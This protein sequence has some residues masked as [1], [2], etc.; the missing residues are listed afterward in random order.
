VIKLAFKGLLARKLRTVLTGFA[1]V[2]GVAFVAG[3]FI[4]TDTID[5]SFKDLFERTSKGV[6]VSVQSKL[7]VEAD[8]A[9]PPTMPASTL[10][11]VQSVDGV[12]EAA[13]SVSG[14]VNLLDRDGKPILSNGPPTI[15]VTTGPERFDPLTYVE[16]GK[17]TTDDQIA[18]DKG[19]A[20]EFDF[21]VG[22]KVTVAGRAPAKA[23]DVAGIVTLGDSENLAGSRLVL[24][25]LPEGQRVT[26][27]DG[28]DD[29]SVAADG[30]TSPE[31]LK[32][33]IAKELGPE[34]AVRTGKEQAE[35]QA[36]DLS[37]ALGFIRTALLV[38]AA[39]ALL[40]GSF[41]IFNTFSVTVA[42]RTKEFALLRTIG[43]SRGQVLRSVLVETFVIGLIA[44]LVGIAL[45]LALA[46]GLAALLTSFGIDLGTSGTVLEPRTII[47]GLVVGIVATV[48]SGFVPARRATR[49][50]PVAAMRDSVTPATGK[51]RRRRIVVAFVVEALGIVLLLWGLLGDP[52][53]A[54]TTALVLGLGTLLMIFGFALLAPTLVRPL[55]GVIGRPL[56]RFQGLTGMLARENTR[57]QPQ[58]TAV[59]ASALM[60]GV[61][62]VV[63]VAIF[64]AGLRAT[65]DQGIDEQVK[66]VSIITHQDGFSPLPSEIAGEVEK[67]DGVTAVSRLRFATG[68]VAGE[69]G[70]TTVTGIDPETAR[71]VIKLK[72]AEGSDEVLSSIGTTGVIVPKEFATKH[73]LKVGSP[74]VLEAPRGNEV[75]Y[76]V[77]GI[78]EP[79]AGVIGGVLASNASLEA[80]WD[81]K[82]VAFFLVAGDDPESVTKGEEAALAGF[83]AAK[84]QTIE[85]FKDEQNKQVDALVGLVYALLSLSVIVALLGIVNTLALSVHERTRELGLLRAVGMSRRQVRRMV[86]AESVI[87][88]AIGAVLGIVLGVALAAIVSRPLAQDG[89][90]FE[91]PFGTLIAVVILASIAGVVAAIPP[92]RRA[93]KVDVLRAVTTE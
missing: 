35:K 20:D 79:G 53:D 85:G 52:G 10:E 62:L 23:Y 38:F 71:D 40:V 37:D 70:N 29:I 68:R 15:A 28:Y 7:A 56:A 76:R 4:F 82:D 27:H 84:P 91:I 92:A 61:A 12:E 13:G 57:R 1:V 83:P 21:K 43:A 41:L 22:D 77:R 33:A 80:D 60:I 30:G 14:D 72:W 59:T 74:L 39:V 42:Q 6:D 73:D 63:L 16:G 51:V 86:R 19:T 8:F 24:F 89:F 87:T 64:A 36:Q 11:R 48:V 93:A 34:F 47:A 50:E 32:A 75:T 54:A 31:Q 67:V 69:S 58:R 9:A 88:A 45:G 78:Y 5:A 25:T 49:I 66:A 44:S 18:I 26:G 17:P 90:V 3:T 2:L 55:S 65:I 81:A 46:P